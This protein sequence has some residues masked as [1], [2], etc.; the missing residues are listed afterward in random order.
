MKA[1]AIPVVQMKALAI[2]VGCEL[3]ILITGLGEA[4]MNIASEKDC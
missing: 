2:P 4:L 1:L 3:L